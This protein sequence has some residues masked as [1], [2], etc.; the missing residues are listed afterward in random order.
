MQLNPGTTIAAAIAAMQKE[1]EALGTA[2]SVLQAL[3]ANGVS[4]ST[5]VGV[6]GGVVVPFTAGRR[7]RRGGR[8]PSIAQ[9]SIDILRAAGRPLHGLRELIPEL[10]AQG[11]RIKHKSG[12]ATTLMR[13]GEVERTAPGTFRFKG[14]AATTG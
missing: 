3:V 7:A 13:T 4:P 5:A 8:K 14:G 12:L 2:I 9:A 11:V 6:S 10:E 1:R